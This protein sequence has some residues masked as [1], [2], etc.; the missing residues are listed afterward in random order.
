MNGTLLHFRQNRHT[1]KGRHLLIEVEGVDSRE[2]AE[3]LVG[4]HV[5]YKT[6][7]GEI[8]GEIASAHGNSGVVRAIFERGLPGQALSQTVTIA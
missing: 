3:K 1:T 8:K 4:K 2:Q 5:V 7:N 6:K